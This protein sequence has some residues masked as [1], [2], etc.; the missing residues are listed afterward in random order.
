MGKTHNHKQKN[1]TTA[2]MPPQYNAIS[3]TLSDYYCKSSSLDRFKSDLV[4]GVDLRYGGIQLTRAY[5]TLKL[6]AASEIFPSMALWDH[7]R[8]FPHQMAYESSG[9]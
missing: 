8:N 6:P 2:N 1:M 4:V 7:H 9:Q 5:F 3:I